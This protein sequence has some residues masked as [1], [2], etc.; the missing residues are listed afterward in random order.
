MLLTIRLPGSRSTQQ[1]ENETYDSNVCRMIARTWFSACN[2]PFQKWFGNRC[3]FD[4]T[5]APVSL[6]FDRTE[7]FLGDKKRLVQ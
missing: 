2:N 3:V 4:H 1:M 5:Q 7:A 6:T